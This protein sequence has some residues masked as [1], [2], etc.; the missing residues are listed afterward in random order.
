[1]SQGSLMFSKLC[2]TLCSKKTK[3]HLSQILCIIGFQGS[4]AVHFQDFNAEVLRYLTIPNLNANLSEKTSSVSVS[5]TEVRFFGGEWSEVHQILPLVDNNDETD[6]KGCYDIILMAETIYS[7][8]AQKSLYELIK[9]VHSY[10][11]L[12]KHKLLL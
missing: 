1:M 11:L 7:I 8:P 4:D 10:F 2:Y 9:R 3:T 12:D 5:E 6:K